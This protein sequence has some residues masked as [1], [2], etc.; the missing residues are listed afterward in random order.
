M[1]QSSLA[2]LLFG[3]LSS[4]LSVGSLAGTCDS[5]RNVTLKQRMDEIKRDTCN[6]MDTSVSVENSPYL[7]KSPDSGCDLGLSLPGLPNLGSLGLDGIDSC[8]IL[9]SV[10][11]DFVK[12]VNRELQDAMD[13]AAPISED[14][15]IDL[16]DT[17][18]ERI[19]A[20][21]AEESNNSN[22]N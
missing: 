15:N 16:N 22:N 13:V 10:T 14:Q 19:E 18:E 9:K 3:F 11:G 7:Y 2:I 6:E 17:I 4:T 1:K 12:E 21:R 5:S 20:A 8:R